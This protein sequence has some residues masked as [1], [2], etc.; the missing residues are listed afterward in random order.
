MWSHNR[1][2]VFGRSRGRLFIRL[3]RLLPERLVGVC[4]GGENRF[5]DRGDLRRFPAAAA[6]AAI[7]AAE[8]A[9]EENI[10]AHAQE[11]AAEEFAR[12]RVFFAGLGE[13]E[14]ATADGAS[15]AE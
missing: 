12:G 6:F 10:E 1:V 8:A 5:V 7:D 15:E 14:R 3:G 4:A 13:E 2:L 9:G 11:P